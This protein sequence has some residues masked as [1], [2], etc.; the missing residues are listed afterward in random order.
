MSYTYD[1]KNYTDFNDAEDQK[2]FELIPH[3][4]I[5]KVR[6]HITPGGFDDEKRGWA[7]GYATQNPKTGSVYL[8]CDFTILEGKYH[9]QKVFSNIGLHSENGEGWANMG[10]GFIKAILNS[11]RGIKP[12]D[13][14]PKAIE[15]RR[16]PRGLADLD[17][18]EFAA[19]IEQEE[20]DIDGKKRINN[21]I[22]RAITPDHK[23]YPGACMTASSPAQ[24][25]DST[26][27]HWYSHYK[28]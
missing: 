28:S 12:D 9:K 14:S 18:I 1:P 19:L 24:G 8:K 16:T 25:Q 3:K 10:R 26:T 11:A 17:G 6:L 20:K 2:S 5:A 23:E 4:T 7:G 21:V 15:G 27:Q 22:K 13:D